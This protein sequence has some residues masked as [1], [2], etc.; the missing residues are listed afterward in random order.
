VLS[1]QRI[2]DQGLRKAKTILTWSI[3]TCMGRATGSRTATALAAPV[4]WSLRLVVV[5]RMT[6][7][8]A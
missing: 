2:H 4:I 1:H 7:N 5:T 3:R 6:L 8:G